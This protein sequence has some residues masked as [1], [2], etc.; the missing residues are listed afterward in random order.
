MDSMYVRYRQCGEQVLVI[1][2]GTGAGVKSTTA[3]PANEIHRC[4]YGDF[5]SRWRIDIKHSEIDLQA[6]RLGQ[7]S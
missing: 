5:Y 1:A 2:V 3:A 6:Q 7:Y 4:R